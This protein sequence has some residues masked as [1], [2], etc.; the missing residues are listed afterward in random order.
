VILFLPITLLLLT[1]IALGFV[2]RF[3]PKIRSFWLVNLAGP[4]LAWLSLLFLWAE[5]PISKATIYWRISS[6]AQL[7]LNWL[8]DERSWA[9]LFG[10]SSV[11]LAS[12]LNNIRELAER[13]IISWLPGTGIA[14]ASMA[15]VVAGNLLTMLITW[16]LVDILALLLQL[17]VSK[18][19]SLLHKGL[20]SFAAQL[21][22]YVFLIWTIAA[23]GASASLAIEQLSEVSF[24]LLILAAGLRLGVLPLNPF[25]LNKANESD[26]L[27]IHIRLSLLLPSFALLVRIDSPQ[28]VYGIALSILVFLATL[29][30]SFFYSR[31]TKIQGSSSHWA[32]ALGG[33]V[34]AS[35]IVGESR[36][37]LAWA[38]V[39]LFLG[40]LQ[41]L[42]PSKGVFHRFTII[43]GVF[44]L[45]GLPFS[46]NFAGLTLVNAS[47]NIISYAFLVPIAVLLIGWVRKLRSP[48]EERVVF[49]RWESAMRQV[50]FIIL[51][52]S[53]F[54]LGAGM[55][56]F[57]RI[58]PSIQMSAPS[59]GVLILAAIFWFA[60]ASRISV[61]PNR[62]KVLEELFSLRWLYRSGALILRQNATILRS[63]G[64]ILEGRAGV[65]WALL[66]V[67]LL[68]SLIS[69]LSL[70]T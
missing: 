53:H 35:A 13:D 61:R 48:L 66:L 63:I 30:G 8:M 38:L 43:W 47:G 18:D 37:T 22:S 6:G 17:K 42:K 3:Q 54:V 19:Q 15:T 62:I 65:L 24:L 1:A 57:L 39:A 46:P 69:Q 31:S 14:A 16:M 40:T 64:A 27:P 52:L 34:L 58:Q 41:F 55:I 28:S 12:Y 32:L 49:E 44:L 33:L 11:L 36:A 59:F 70:S 26:M 23:S 10:L 21:G 9:L 60:I 56:S 25:F 45:A 29:Y 67:A 68:L 2:I 50:G 7:E 5:L 20:S 51:V 4:G